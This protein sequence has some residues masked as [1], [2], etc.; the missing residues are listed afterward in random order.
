[1][2]GGRG[3][4][5]G[6]KSVKF[7]KVCIWL[8]ATLVMLVSIFHYQ[9]VFAKYEHAGLVNLISWLMGIIFDLPGLLLLYYFPNS[10]S[11]WKWTVGFLLLFLIAF[12]HFEY[13]SETIKNDLTRITLSAVW[14]FM[15][16]VCTFIAV[17]I[18]KI[19]SGKA[20]A[21]RESKA[22]FDGSLD[23]L[24][25]EPVQKPAKKKRENHQR[26]SRNTKNMKLVPA[27]TGAR[28]VG[29]NSMESIG[30]MPIDGN[31]AGANK[32]KK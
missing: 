14:P 28:L 9:P 1:L 23:F 22:K 25:N 21:V 5:K 17:Q 7:A 13:Y 16:V 11:G 31:N 24:K 26:V 29:V 8:V 10:K 20:E 3:K 6:M 18:K 27:F 4:E 2:I 15:I 30:S 32:Y 12:F 19:E